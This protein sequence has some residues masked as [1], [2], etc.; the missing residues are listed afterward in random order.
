MSQQQFTLLSKGTGQAKFNLLAY[1]G[2]PGAEPEYCLIFVVTNGGEKIV[3]EDAKQARCEDVKNYLIDIF[4]QDT[5]TTT[6]SCDME[7]GDLTRERLARIFASLGRHTLGL[8]QGT[9]LAGMERVKKYLVGHEG[10]TAWGEILDKVDPNK[11]VHPELASGEQA[12]E[13]SMSELTGQAPAAQAAPPP[14][15]PAPA[16]QAAPPPPPAPAPVEDEDESFESLLGGEEE[17]EAPAEPPLQRLEK[18]SG[19]EGKLVYFTSR[20]SKILDELSQAAKAV[21]GDIAQLKGAISTAASQVKKLTKDVTPVPADFFVNKDW[22]SVN[23]ELN[24]VFVYQL[25]FNLPEYK[26]KSKSEIVRLLSMELTPSSKREPESIS[27]EFLYKKRFDLMPEP[28]DHLRDL[29]RFRFG[30][31]LALEERFPYIA[32]KVDLTKLYYCFKDENHHDR[33]RL[34]D[35]FCFR[36]LDGRSGMVYVPYEYLGTNVLNRLLNDFFSNPWQ[37]Q[38]AQPAV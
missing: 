5:A 11:S 18:I 34:T 25:H 12:E 9:P 30:K 2:A 35:I 10:D 6:L 1:V 31:D 27:V 14:P 36:E 13:A 23:P 37:G 26:E 38:G 19:V 22:A 7:E 21:G 32:R 4:K 16:A 17:E 8:P 15:P 24:T 33:V 28:G 3:I 20:Y 29:L